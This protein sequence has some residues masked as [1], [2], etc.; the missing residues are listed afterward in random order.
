MFFCNSFSHLPD[1]LITE[2]LPCKTVHGTHEV[3][4]CAHENAGDRIGIFHHKLPLPPRSVHGVT[5]SY[6]L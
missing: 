1:Q 6:R 3:Q 5:I 4:S 2:D